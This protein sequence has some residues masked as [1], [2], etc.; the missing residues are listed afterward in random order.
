MRY[1]IR[2]LVSIIFLSATYATFAQGLEYVE[3]KGQWNSKVKF[4]SDMGGSTFFLQQQ[5]YKVLLNNKDDFK[6]ISGHYSS[7]NHVD[8][9]NTAGKPVDPSTKDMV[10]HSFA[11]EVNFVGSSPNARIVPDKPLNTYNNYYLGNDKSK[12]ASGCKIYRAVTYEDIYK[13]VDARYYTDNGNLKYDLII[14]PGADADKIAL[15]FDGVEKLSVK[16][17]SLVVKTSLGEV[18]ELR[19]YCYQV[20][21]KGRTDV[22]AKYIIEGNTV[23]FKINNYSKTA[24]LVIDPT[25]VFASFTGS[26]TDNWGYTATY[27]GS[28]NFYSGGIS[29][30]PGYPVSTGAFQT[31]YVGGNGGSGTPPYDVA[32]LKLNA[33]GTERLYATFLGGNGYEQPHSL[34]VDNDGNLVIAGRTLSTD[35]PTTANTFGAGGDY[36][37]FISKLNADGSILL[38]SRKFGGT[39][40]DGVNIRPKESIGPVSINRNYG[41]DARSE[42]NIDNNN[43]IYLASCTRSS[44]FPVSSNAFQK[45][46]GGEQD[47]VVIKT[48]SDLNTVLFSSF[49]GGNGEDAAF[50]LSLNPLNSNIYVDGATTSDNLNGTGGN[51]GPNL[52]SSFQGGISGGGDGFVSIIRNDGTSLIKTCYVCTSGNDM[53]YGVQFDKLGFPYITGTTTVAFP[54]SANAAFKSQANGKQFITKMQPDLS[55]IV[56]STNFGKGASVP[57]ISI[58]AFLV[59]RCDNVYVAGWGGGLNVLE[60]FP[61]ANTSGLSTTSNAIRATSDGSDFYFFVLEKNGLSQLYG[62]FFGNLD[63]SPDIG[64]HV[65]GGTSRFDKEGVIYEAL[66]ANCGGEGI[67]PATPGVW[68][69][70]NLAAPN[71]CNQAAVKIAF[72]LA[73]VGSGVQ[74]AING[75]KRDTSGCL[76]VTVDFS[77]TIATGKKFIWSFND[78]S[79]DVTTLVPS[80][81]HTFNNLGTFKVR[82]I[83]ID[84]LTCNISDTSYTNIRVRDD[85]AYIGFTNVK[86]PPCDSLKYQFNNTSTAPA[87]KPFGTQSFQWDFGDG[88]IIIS[89]A[90][91][92]IHN[93]PAPGQYKIALRLIDTSYCN[94]P[95]S[96][97]ITI[98]IAANVLA[99]FETPPFG[100]APYDAVFTNTSLAGQEFFWDFGDGTLSNAESPVHQYPV[101]GVFT[102]KLKVVDANTCNITDSTEQTITVSAKPTSIFSYSPQTPKENTPFQFT[103]FSL[104]ATSYKWIFGDGDTLVTTKRDTVVAHV[105]N[106]SGTYNACLVAYN[107]FGCS[108][109]SCQPLQAIIVP[110]VDVPNALT[111][112]GD[113]VNDGVTVKGFGIQKM[114]WRIYNRWGTLIFQTSNTK[115]S[116]DGKYNGAVQPQEVYVYVLDVTFSDGTTYRKKG[117]ITLL[118]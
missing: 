112:N 21:G 62:T 61:N 82:L 77:D 56:Y 59:D 86:L 45:T 67:F 96:A 43:N 81:S 19:P 63:P 35:F 18:S 17:G 111:P 95:D 1:L 70:R 48:S 66:C 80:I 113:G 28:G 23:R 24:T 53:L 5:G 64:D 20:D 72:E 2:F 51:N 103:N 15:R 76:P 16:N 8:K 52:F 97:V 74:S 11:Y 98:N 116:W 104:G 79:P 7:H 42:V 55:G 71:G 87:G 89:N 115:Q 3:N 9:T 38:G 114:N 58:T 68:G 110:V 100:C 92:I 107:N 31:V 88:T 25:L 90:P 85:K 13:G 65:D 30:G 27:D 39:D 33:N 108:D 83:S 99:Q 10:L 49:L 102:I 57:D 26:T 93:Y 94:S 101:P 32:V 105:Y 69:P 46:F 106:A 22:E 117:D 41:D 109:T 84:S 75:V 34:I 40:K 36:D 12:W 91:S 6:K 44:N 118:R 4:K 14:H 29:F 37:I 50:V 78:G 54:V 47:G 60:G 73:G